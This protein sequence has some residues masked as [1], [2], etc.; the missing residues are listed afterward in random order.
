MPKASCT[1]LPSSPNW[2]RAISKISW[3]KARRAIAWLAREGGAQ[4]ANPDRIVVAGHSGVSQV[5]QRFALG[6][7]VIAALGVLFTVIL[8]EIERYLVPWK[9]AR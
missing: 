1:S 2:P 9:A 4:G 5:V 3:P 8:N 7:L 6:L